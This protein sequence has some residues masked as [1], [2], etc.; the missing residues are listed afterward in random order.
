MFSYNVFSICL[1]G[2]ICI[3]DWPEIQSYGYPFWRHDNNIGMVC[4]SKCDMWI[5]WKDDGPPCRCLKMLLPV[6]KGNQMAVTLFAAGSQWILIPM[7]WS[8][9]QISSMK[10][11]TWMPI[12]SMLSTWTLQPGKTKNLGFMWRNHKGI[13][14][15][16][17][18]TEDTTCIIALQKS[19]PSL[20]IHI[21]LGDD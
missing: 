14:S 4:L 21:D 16:R 2:V 17:E 7:I 10:W 8:V 6:L 12:C 18:A 15:W 19:T 9:L 13:Q 3:R 1:G 5:A 11:F 20:S